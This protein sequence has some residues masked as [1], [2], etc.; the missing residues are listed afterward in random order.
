MKPD[1]ALNAQKKPSDFSAETYTIL[2]FGSGYAVFNQQGIKV[3]EENTL[4]MTMAQLF[5][6]IRRDLV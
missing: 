1:K 6:L 5:K 2:R 3:S 4:P